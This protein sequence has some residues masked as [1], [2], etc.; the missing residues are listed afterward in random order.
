M[1]DT[2]NV[3]RQC[4]I[5]RHLLLKK[6]MPSWNVDDLIVPLFLTPIF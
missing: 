2:S 4:Y 3:K 6:L 1:L 5:F